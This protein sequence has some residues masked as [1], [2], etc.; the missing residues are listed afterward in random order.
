VRL[1]I[2]LCLTLPGCAVFKARQ[3][4]QAAIGPEPHQGAHAFA[5]LGDLYL[6]SQPDWVEWDRRMTACVNT[7]LG[8]D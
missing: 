4:C 1:L 7:K 2:A 5:L 8:R 6:Q 3:D